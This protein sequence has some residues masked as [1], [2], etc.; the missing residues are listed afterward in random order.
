MRIRLDVVDEKVNL[1]PME[2]VYDKAC[3]ESAEAVRNNDSDSALKIL[4]KAIKKIIEAKAGSPWEAADLYV[5]CARIYSDKKESDLELA[6]LTKAVE[7]R[8]FDW[9]YQKRAYVY[10]RRGDYDSAIADYTKAIENE[11]SPESYYWRGEVFF[12]KNDYD[13][14]IADFL[15]SVE[16]CSS[17]YIPQGFMAKFRWF[18]SKWGFRANVRRIFSRKEACKGCLESYYMCGL[19]YRKKG[20][21]ESAVKYLNK[22]LKLKPD[23]E[24]ARELR[25]EILG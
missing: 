5:K 18:F 24:K 7:L 16:C 11:E 19:A 8:G 10:E 22:A 13:S 2:G 15:K 12:K 4:E 23:F 1:A 20:D 6:A 14:A 9:D 21:W 3:E 17:W 25:G